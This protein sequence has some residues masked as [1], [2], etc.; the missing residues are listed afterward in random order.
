MPPCFQSPAGEARGG[1][2]LFDLCPDAFE[3]GPHAV[4]VGPAPGP[5][6]ECPVEAEHVRPGQVE[7][8]G[9]VGAVRGGLQTIAPDVQRLVGGAHTEGELVPWFGD[10][11][12]AGRPV[13]GALAI[14][15]DMAAEAG[16]D[17]RT[18]GAVE[19]LGPEGLGAVLADPGDVAHQL[20]D[21]LLY[22]S[23]A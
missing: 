15:L 17:G 5:A 20:P 22:T 18:R 1:G 10:E 3:G 23:D 16:T 19:P 14:A 11:H 6:E 8:L 21:C 13:G 12:R 2:R 4:A 7:G 9:D